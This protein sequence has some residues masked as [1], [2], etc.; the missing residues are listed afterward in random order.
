M[1]RYADVYSDIANKPI[2]SE[3][4]ENEIE[5]PSKM[6]RYA[7]VYSDIANKPV[8]SE[9][10]ENEIVQ[11]LDINTFVDTYAKEYTNECI[12]HSTSDTK[13][14]YDDGIEFWQKTEC[15]KMKDRV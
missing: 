1:I 12:S 13:K 4:E 5:I 10:E 15:Q 3:P 9:P 2:K 6:I 8:K 14:T 7:D 11:K